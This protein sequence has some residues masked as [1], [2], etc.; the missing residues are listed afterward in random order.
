MMTN[1]KKFIGYHGVGGLHTF[2]MWEAAV[3]MRPEDWMEGTVE[4]VLVEAAASD[5]FAFPGSS[6]LSGLDSTRPRLVLDDR[7]DGGVVC[8]GGVGTVEVE[9]GVGEDEE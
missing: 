8:S 2:L 9:D 7:V 4:V 1:F 6:P 5:V 3:W